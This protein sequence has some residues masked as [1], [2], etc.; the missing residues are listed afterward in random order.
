V[1]SRCFF[2]GD[3]LIDGQLNLICRGKEEVLVNPRSMAVLKLLAAQPGDV[4]SANTLLEEV[5]PGNHFDPNSVYKAIRELR[6]ALGDT[7]QHPSVIQTLP[8]RGYRLLIEPFVVPP[9]DTVKA[10][11][12]S[13]TFNRLTRLLV[14]AGAAAGVLI[15][16]GVVVSV[17][18]PYSLEFEVHGKGVRIVTNDDRD[19]WLTSTI[20]ELAETLAQQPAVKPLHRAWVERWSPLDHEV[21][22]NRIGDQLVVTLTPGMQGVTHVDRYGHEG[23]ATTFDAT[24]QRIVQ[25]TVTDVITLLDEKRR[26]FMALQGTAN[27]HAWHLWLDAHWL[28]RDLQPAKIAQAT[29]LLHAALT[30]DPRFE[31]AYTSLAWR[32]RRLASIDA[33]QAIEFRDKIV[34]LAT[35]AKRWEVDER[36]LDVLDRVAA[37][38]FLSEPRELAE[39][40]V[41]T[42]S[43]NPNQVDALMQF[44]RILV[45]AGF[46]EEGRQY[47][48]RA[49]SIVANS[50]QVDE[51]V[52]SWDLSDQMALLEAFGDT[53][54]RIRRAEA[55]LADRP[56]LADTIH[57]LATRYAQI[58]DADSA[59]YYIERLNKIDSSGGWAASARIRCDALLGRLPLDSQALAEALASRQVNSMD[60][61]F[62][63]FVLG[64]IDEGARA[65]RA[66]EPRFLQYLWSYL[67]NMQT[68]FDPRVVRD[69]RFQTMLD[70]LGVGPR[71]RAYLGHK[72]SELAEA[73]GITQST[74]FAYLDPAPEPLRLALR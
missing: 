61:G 47:V 43:A 70:E 53:A 67:A 59:E 55:L 14:I 50:P 73:T 17:M 25:T 68:Y 19:P 4:I 58:G 3:Y 11:G 22:L 35:E 63:Y 30:E 28:D 60:R 8:R 10:E 46:V 2:L 56:F 48:A 5:W 24:R 74:S 69:P 12:I 39:R 21:R 23:T 71:W 1:E 64:E 26:R 41:R 15:L 38:A 65:W 52:M 29:E 51:G 42:L 45:G 36:T 31:A 27:L 62:A 32:Y 13:A 16:A 54:A 18:Q 9:D 7:A 44:H 6:E 40:T 49:N 66:L 33:K 57:G 37:H 72:I 34:A 20:D